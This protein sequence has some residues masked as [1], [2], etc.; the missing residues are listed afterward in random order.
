[1]G[2][3]SRNRVRGN[4][5]SGNGYSAQGNNFGIGLENTGTNDNV[6][7][8]N[9]VIG[10]TNGLFMTAGVQGNIIRRNLLEGNPPVQVA[11]D[12]TANTGFDIKNLADAGANTF[13]GNICGTSVNA[14]CPSVGP[15]LTASPNPI[16]VTSSALQ[17][18]TTISWNAPGAEVVEIRIGSP[19]GQLLTRMGFRGSVQ[20]GTWVSDGMTFYLQDVTGGRP[21]TSDYTLATL[22]VHLQRSNAANF[23]F[24][25]G[26]HAWAFG[27]TTSLLGLVL[28][29]IVLLQS[30]SRGKC[31]RIALN[32]A[33]LLALIGLKGLSQTTTPAQASET[34]RPSASSQI[35]AQQKQAKLDQMIAAGASSKELAQYFSETHGCKNCHTTGHEGKLGFTAKGKE[36]AQGFEGCISTLKAMSIIAKVPEDQRSVTQRQRVQRFEEF[37]C[38]TCH[39][40]TPAKMELTAVG[41]KLAHLHLGCV[42]VEKLL[43]TNP[44][45]KR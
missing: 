42:E 37:G 11:V 1:L 24:R 25:S 41:A 10:N 27:A 31:V 22:A 23:H 16:P 19:G 8:D 5:L 35:S 6:V 43:A 38:A 33:I 30:G 32:G 20:T 9:T 18:S 17:G 14:P 39:K 13:V 44:A 21:L 7:E 4:R 36:G 26:P 3:T 2:G 15:S 28:S 12:H 34:A 29:G 45:S 40:V